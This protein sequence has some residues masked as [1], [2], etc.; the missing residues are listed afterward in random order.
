MILDSLT[1]ENYRV[2]RGPEK[3]N[4]AKG[5]KHV[6][7]I[8]GTNEVGKTTIMNAITWCLYGEEMFRESGL[9]SLL[10]NN[11]ANS[12]E[13]NETATVRVELDMTD[14]K[15]RNVKISRSLDFFKADNESIIKDS[16]SSFKILLNEGGNDTV[17]SET[18]TFISTHLPRKIREYFLFDGEQLGDYFSKDNKEIKE[19]VFKL[20]QLN[21]LKK[22]SKH[23]YAMKKEYAKK[24]DKL[25]PE[26]AKL[27][28]E[29]THKV[30]LL[31]KY[32]IE[33]DNLTTEVDELSAKYDRNEEKIRNM[34]ENPEKLFADKDKL[35]NLLNE[36]VSNVKSME[37]D[38]TKF[39]ISS[40]PMVF[41]F[42]I[43]TGFKKQTKELEEKGYIPARY[44]REFLEYLL[45]EGECIC[46]TDLSEGS[47]AHNKIVELCNQTDEITDLS[48]NINQLL[49]KVNGL[50]NNNNLNSFENDLKNKLNR[51]S[52]AEKRKRELDIEYNE[53][54]EKIENIGIGN[55]QDLINNNK[56]ILKTLTNKSKERGAKEEQIKILNEDIN[57]LSLEI[58]KEKEKAP[59]KEELEFAIDFC[60]KIRDTVENIYDGL[61]EDLHDELEQLTSEEF[62]NMHWKEEYSN[63]IIDKNYN[64]SLLKSDGTSKSP[65]DLSA[66]GK[67]VLALSFMTALNSLSGFELPILIDTPFGR[68]D[69][70]IKENFGKYL[71]NYT[72]DK[73]I[74]FLVTGSENSVN[75]RKGIEE[76]IGKEYILDFN[77][78]EKG[79]VTRVR[80]IKK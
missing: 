62:K 40:F 71:H 55:A 50:L 18:A 77:E 3:I 52:V 59:I 32:K 70:E 67:L 74:T 51:I 66:G 20:S 76:Y 35:E 5:D 48:E 64:I 57:R 9:E 54:L 16:E 29:Q 39:L 31:D 23:I 46:G 4:F 63:V 27:L 30:E 34:G 1:L 44:K 24:L 17:V 53:V 14:N 13:I 37:Q 28:K 7:I 68:L 10:N 58:E 8:Q 47:K 15:G 33:F 49:G 65:N 75:F 42:E 43:L 45:D 78:K 80:E 69:E 19:S 36:S 6:T 41:G 22:V 21:L 61:E 56:G 72:K 79:E 60:D 73:Q 38:Y 2:Y 26:I 12:L 11:K 25:N